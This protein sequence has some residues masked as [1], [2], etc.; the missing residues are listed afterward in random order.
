MAAIGPGLI[1]DVCID[2]FQKLQPGKPISVIPHRPAVL[3]LDGEREIV[4]CEKDSAEV[5]LSLV[6]PNF[7]NIKRV[8]ENPQ[9]F[10]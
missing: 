9:P 10:S 8:L 4:L 3:A 6:G 5:I 1:Y 7:N 2:E